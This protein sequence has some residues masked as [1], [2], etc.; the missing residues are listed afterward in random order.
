M[1]EK[2]FAAF[3]SYV[4]ADDEHDNGRLTAIRKWL[5]EEI[6]AQTGETFEIFQDR[7]DI[8][9]GHAWEERINGTLD[10]STFLLAAITPRYLKSEYCRKEFERFTERERKLGRN[11]LILPLLY[12]DTP[13]LSNKGDS[14]AIAISSRQY[15]DWRNLRFEPWTNPD[16]TKRLAQLAKMICDAILREWPSKPLMKE[17]ESYFMKVTSSRQ[18]TNALKQTAE[19]EKRK[20]AETVE[21]PTLIVDPMPRRGDYTTITKAIES[22]EPGTRILIR[23]GF[24]R[25][26]LVIDKPLEL[27]GDGERKEIVIEAK[28]ANIIHFK[29]EFGRVSNLTLRQAGGDKF[30]GIKIS[31]GRPELEDCDITSQS[32]SVIAIHDGADPRVRRNSIHDGKEGGVYVFNNGKGTL[33]DNNLYKNRLSAVEVKTGGDPTIRR[34]K[35][36]NGILIGENGLGTIEDNHI[37]GSILSGVEIKLGGHPIVRRNHIY[38]NK[39]N[40][41]LIWEQGKGIIEENDI[42]NNEYS[43]VEIRE[44]GNPVLRGNSIKDN[45]QSGIFVHDDGGGLFEG[46]KITGNMKSWNID[47]TSQDNIIAQN[48]IED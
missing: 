16:V 22:A 7:D 25:E 44:G 11:D 4:H 2:T 37:F 23:P 27:I 43:G 20:P 6:S 31:Q 15:A 3:F 36:E 24:Y 1:A 30:F 13:A 18:E 47:N 35:I 38:N 14:V 32:L 19:P 12:M 8:H 9:W 10:N 41:I 28:G 26:A 33:E 21:P 5:E 46:N 39:Q 29:T 40:G 17:T 45:K 42:F 48:N 34:N